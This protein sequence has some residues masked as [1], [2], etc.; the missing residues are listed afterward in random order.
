MQGTTLPIVIFNGWSGATIRGT[1]G[2]R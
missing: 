2:I 1:R